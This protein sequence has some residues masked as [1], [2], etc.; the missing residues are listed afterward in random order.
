[1]LSS[2]ILNVPSFILFNTVS[3]TG[4]TKS[5][6]AIDL[7]A[8]T[9]Y[10]TYVILIIDVIK[11]DVALCWTADHAYALFM[12]ILAYIY[13]KKADWQKKRI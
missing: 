9:L 1:M 2:Q 10:T 5:G 7:V 12:F 3:G 13:M 4:N 8:L 11:A 6:L